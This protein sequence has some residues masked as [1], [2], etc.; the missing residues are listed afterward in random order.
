MD[1]LNIDPTGPVQASTPSNPCGFAPLSPCSPK[2]SDGSSAGSAGVA[3]GATNRQA[4][5]NSPY[6]FHNYKVIWTPTWTA[7]LVDTTVYRNITFSIWRPQSIRQILRT[8]VGDSRDPVPATGRW[9]AASTGSSGG[10]TSAST[11]VNYNKPRPDAYVFIKRIKYTPMDS[12]GNYITAAMT[13]LR[14]PSLPSTA[15]PVTSPPVLI[16]KP[17]PSPTI[18]AGRRLLDAA[19]DIATIQA[20]VAASVPGLSSDQVGVT[21]SSYA[22]YGYLMLIDPTGAITTQ[23]WNIGLQ[24]TLLAGLDQDTGAPSGSISMVSINTLSADMVCESN[25]T[26]TFPACPLLGARQDSWVNLPGYDS[27]SSPGLG[28][29]SALLI[30]FSITGYASTAAANADLQLLLVD[31][32]TG[33]LILRWLGRLCSG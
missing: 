11:C 20:Q 31:S 30:E 6:A 13:S 15:V 7:W 33:A 32:G 17:L 27:P 21:L 4:L 22:L 28:A 24:S 16:T 14:S 18:A 10:V 25:A 8:N 23:T 2:N 5:Y 12:Q 19:S 29:A 1:A 26:T 3:A 9:C